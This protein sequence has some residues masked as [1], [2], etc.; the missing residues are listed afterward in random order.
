LRR[1]HELAE[2]LL[3]KA[4]SDEYAFERLSA[5]PDAPR[6]VVL[7]HAQQ[8]AEKMIKAVLA[9]SSVRFH[10][11]HD[12]TELVDLALDNGIPFPAELRDVRPLTPFAVHFRYEL[13]SLEITQASGKLMNTSQAVS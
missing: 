11:T 7:F 10:P 12:F 9:L 13:M 6:E 5:D 8:A 1:S 2:L 3:R 4:A